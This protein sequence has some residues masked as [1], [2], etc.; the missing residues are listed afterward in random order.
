MRINS[1]FAKNIDP[2]AKFEVESL[3]DVVVIAGPNGVGKSRLIASLLQFF[4]DPRPNHP[5]VRMIVQATSD[6]ERTAWGKEQIDTD[7]QQDAN[8]FRAILHKSQRRNNY[9]STVL[10]FE[11]DRSI[12]NIQPYTF[13][14]DITDPWLEDVGYNLGFGFLRDRFQ[15]VQH[16]IFR[17][18][19]SQRRSIAN[20]AIELKNSGVQEMPLD[21]S[22][23]LH[24]FKNAF[25]QLLAPKTLLDADLRRQQLQYKYQDKVL[26][27]ESLS[28]GEK[29]I[30]NIVFDFIL[31]NPS[32]C[33][34][35]F[36]EPELHLHPEFSYKL[37]QTL[38]AQGSHNQF[39]FC[40]HS[41][42]IISASLENSVVF[43]TPKI[44]TTENQAISVNR[45]DTTHNA[46][47]LLGE[48]IGII[49][50]GKKLVLIEGQETSQ[51]KQTYGSILKNRFPELVLVPVGGKS[52]IRSFNEVR[53][54]VL[55]QTIWGVDFYMLCDR[56]AVY[57]LGRR[58]VEANISHRL[59]ILPRYH[60]ENYF[61][62]E[63]ILAKIF[64]PMEAETSW[65]RDPEAIN[66]KLR[67]L[68]K[69]IVPYAVALNVAAGL[70]EAIGNIDVMP[71]GL[72]AQSSMSDV[73]EMIHG[74]ANQELQRISSGLKLEGLQEAVQAEFSKLNT[75]IDGNQPA[76]KSEIPGR[77]IF[78]KFA[79]AV[80]MKSGR[81]K[82]LYLKE[83]ASTESNPFAEI[84]E[85]FSAFTS[86]KL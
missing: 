55:N 35:L 79:S 80:G 26:P 9:Q 16:S 84:I 20:R 7:D 38:S 51:D 78:N 74:K 53:D 33:I 44:G 22:D 37:L 2:I 49:S 41:P 28:S 43:I 52:T 64:Q 83:A 36:D 46:L 82:L 31:R 42:D 21:F 69:E 19:E 29:E 58:S 12:R 57:D 13:S 70:R 50:L 6:Q 5:N 47:K 75:A 68:A 45:D 86:P 73:V 34:I 81:L 65:L 54:S 85:L 27:V 8:R 61:L 48:S 15:D 3:S 40:T 67:L 76:W 60:I 24:P 17:R 11:S 1:I 18:V 14:W 66:A 10:N 77:I 59:K 23:P 63:D 25:S 4:V 39:I 32:D 71:K 56:D 62:D 30:V 72:G